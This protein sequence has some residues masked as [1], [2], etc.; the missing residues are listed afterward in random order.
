MFVR[1][2]KGVNVLL[3]VVIALCLFAYP[4]LVYFL[5][6]KFSPRW[7][8]LFL[9]GLFALRFLYLGNNKHSKD[10]L[11]LSAVSAFC[12]A[13]FVI[14]SQQL[15]KFYPVLMNAGIGM[16]FFVSLS[17]K[18]SL[19]ERFANMAKKKPPPEAK[20]Y[21]RRLNVVW[22]SLLILNALVSAYTAWYSSLS[23]WAFYN[24]LLSYVIIGIFVVCELIYRGHYK[25]KYGLIDE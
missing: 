21:L 20:D 18:Q 10:W 3:T 23:V 1:P 14:D 12:L 2:N 7:F 13:V 15:L 17:F 5:I 19:I 9:L 24:G 25:R 11:L 16:M 4:F 8:A 6:D 22:G